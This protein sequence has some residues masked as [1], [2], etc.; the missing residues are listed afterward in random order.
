MRS[1]SSPWA[2]TMM[3]GVS[4]SRFR[5]LAMESPPS[6]GSIRSRMIRSTSPSAS[7]SSMALPSPT[8]TMS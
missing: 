7:A 4:L 1:I 3:I 6:P 8:A 5:R 2:E